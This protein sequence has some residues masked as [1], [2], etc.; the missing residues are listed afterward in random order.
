M[1]DQITATATLMFSRK[2]FHTL[3]PCVLIHLCIQNKMT[4]DYHKMHKFSFPQAVLYHLLH[5]LLRIV[6][7]EEHNESRI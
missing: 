4:D 6:I 1:I 3:G 7:F 2:M 5:R